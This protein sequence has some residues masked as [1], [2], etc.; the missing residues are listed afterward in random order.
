MPW[1][2]GSLL[3]IRRGRAPSSAPV[4]VLRKSLGTAVLRN[5][6]RRRLRH[7][8]RHLP[9]SAARGLVV[10]A[11]PPAARSSFAALCTELTRLVVSLDDSEPKAPR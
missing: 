4:F 2:K 9:A 10:L 11:Q 1:S 3:W 7:I 8:C 6:L 5:R